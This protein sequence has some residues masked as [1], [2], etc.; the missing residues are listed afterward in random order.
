M[1]RVANSGGGEFLDRAST[2]LLFAIV[3]LVLG[4]F[5]TAFRRP[6]SEGLHMQRKAR[7]ASVRVERL[8]AENTA[9]EA[10]IRYAATDR[11]AE[12][13]ARKQGLVRPWETPVRVVYRNGWP[14]SRE[15]DGAAE[16][17]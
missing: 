1:G 7:E 16:R 14:T 15:G 9:L 11:G 3:L 12:V 5:G 10:D 17:P 2:C 13:E 8:R 6:Y 4:V